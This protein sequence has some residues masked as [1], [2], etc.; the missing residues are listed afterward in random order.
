VPKVGERNV[1]ESVLSRFGESLQHGALQPS[2][3][4]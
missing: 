2:I 1:Q 3:T 4:L